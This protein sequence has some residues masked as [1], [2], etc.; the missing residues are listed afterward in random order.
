MSLLLAITASLLTTI[1]HAQLVGQYQLDAHPN[2]TWQ[3]CTTAGTCTSRPARV[4]LDFD[5]RWLHR[6][7]GYII[8]SSPT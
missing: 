2:I 7:D 1:A 6:A 5:W 4:T 3:H 8:P